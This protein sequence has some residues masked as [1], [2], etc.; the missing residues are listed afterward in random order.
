[1]VCFDEHFVK[2][3]T[4]VYDPA[5]NEPLQRFVVFH[6]DGRE[7]A[8]FVLRPSQGGLTRWEIQS[9]AKDALRAARRRRHSPARL[10]L[11]A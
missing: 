11:A 4:L 6:E 1:M 2:F 5:T 9:A 7:L 10:Q 3:D 8:R